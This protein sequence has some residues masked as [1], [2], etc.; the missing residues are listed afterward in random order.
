SILLDPEPTTI[1]FDLQLA[2]IEVDRC[3]TNRGF[4]SHSFSNS[5]LE[6]VWSLFVFENDDN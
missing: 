1:E 6:G 2:V 5:C 4:S 3:S